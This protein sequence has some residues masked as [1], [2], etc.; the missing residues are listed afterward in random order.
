MITSLNYI[1][2]FILSLVQSFKHAVG[3]DLQQT[4]EC[5]VLPCLIIYK[6]CQPV[7]TIKMN[8]KKAFFALIAFYKI[9]ATDHFHIQDYTRIPKVCC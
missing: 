2:K 7:T 3:Y 6:Y 1:L 8:L 4:R 9:T 5:E